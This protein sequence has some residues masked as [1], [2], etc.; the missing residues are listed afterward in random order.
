MIEESFEDAVRIHSSV[1]YDQ[2]QATVTPGDPYLNC[3]DPHIWFEN[4]V[5]GKASVIVVQLC[6]GKNRIVAL[7][8]I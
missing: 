7:T 2:F 5:S 3:M 8:N 4:G 1:F 6:L